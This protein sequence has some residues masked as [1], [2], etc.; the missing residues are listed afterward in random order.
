VDVVW[1]WCRC[2]VDVVWVWCGCGVVVVWMWCGCGVNFLGEGWHL[3]ATINALTTQYSENGSGY[4][5]L[6]SASGTLEPVPWNQ[7]L[8]Q[9]T[10]TKKRKTQ[11][12]R[13]LHDIYFSGKLPY[14]KNS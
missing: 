12:K 10:T 3:R 13:Q 6:D 1:L 7:F 9:I 14:F 5:V 11:H 8:R 2:G 4:P